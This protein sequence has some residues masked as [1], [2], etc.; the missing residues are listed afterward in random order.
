[1]IFPGFPGQVGTL[2]PVLVGPGFPLF[3]ADK[4]PR[5]FQYFFNVLFF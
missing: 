4:I 5:L 2:A 1:M 3:R